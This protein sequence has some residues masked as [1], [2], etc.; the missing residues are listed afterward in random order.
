MLLLALAPQHLGTETETYIQIVLNTKYNGHST[1][2]REFNLFKT[3][4]V[5]HWP[6]DWTASNTKI[7]RLELKSSARITTRVEVRL[8]REELNTTLLW[9]EVR[10]FIIRVEAART[11]DV[12]ANWWLILGQ[13]LWCFGTAGYGV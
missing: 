13:R 3:R 2:C 9:E 6:S 11:G 12:V 5:I 7:L 10:V 1:Q 4:V 8:D